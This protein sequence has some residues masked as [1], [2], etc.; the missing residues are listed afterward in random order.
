MA[1]STFNNLDQHKKQQIIDAAILEFSKTL[2]NHINIQNIIKDAHIP[3]GSFYQYFENKE[4]LYLTIIDYISQK[5][6]VFFMNHQ[7]NYEQPFLSFITD[8][9]VLSYDFLLNHPILYKAGKNMMS[10]DYFKQ[11]EFLKQTKIQTQTFYK[12]L[13]V[14]DQE[15][16]LINQDIDS[17]LLADFMLDFM[18]TEK[19]DVFYTKGYTLHDFKIQINKL[20]T[21]LKKG[22]ETN[23]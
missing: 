10:F 11:F 2:P 3:R 8:V 21:I 15:K 23:V 5:K 13:I 9:Y 16:H 6:Q 18:D 7:L 20:I 14:K 22:I 12:S 19:L 1:K 17:D 4:D